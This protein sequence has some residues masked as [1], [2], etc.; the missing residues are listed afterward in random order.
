M[1]R[2]GKGGTLQVKQLFVDGKRLQGRRR[3]APRSPGWRARARSRSMRAWTCKGVIG[4]PETAIGPG[5]IGNLTGDTKIAYPSSG[6]D[7]DIVDQRLHARRSTAATATRSPAR[8]ASRARATWSSSWGR[9]TPGYK[10]A[11]LPLAGDE[12][13]HHDRQVPRQEGPRATGEAR[14]RRCDL[15]R[16]DRRRAGLQRL[17]VLE[18]ERPAQGHASTSRCSTPATTARP[19]CTSTAAARRPPA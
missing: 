5:N 15:R 18:E 11:P 6:G 14:G 13:E 8:A 7:F 19:T 10:D 1:I 17:P 9:R 4:S 16:R 3:T 2:T 12:A